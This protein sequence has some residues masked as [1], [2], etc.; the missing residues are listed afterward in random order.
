MRYSLSFRD[1]FNIA[2]IQRVICTPQARWIVIFLIVFF[3][4]SII[5]PAHAAILINKTKNVDDPALSDLPASQY[6]PFLSGTIGYT[7]GLEDALK[8]TFDAYHQ[9]AVKGNSQAQNGLSRLYAYG[10]GVPRNSA[11]SLYWARKAADQGNVQAAD[12]LGQYFVLGEGVPYNYAEGA[13]WFHKVLLNGHLGSGAYENALANLAIL[14]G[15]T[16]Y[17]PSNCDDAVSWNTLPSRQKAYAI[18]D[19]TLQRYDQGIGLSA[20]MTQEL[21]L[22]RASAEHELSNPETTFETMQPATVNGGFERAA[23]WYRHTA[24]VGDPAGMT[25]LGFQYLYGLG[26]PQNNTLAY[27]WLRKSVQWGDDAAAEVTLGNM[28]MQ[29]VGVRKNVKRAACWYRKAAAQHNSA[30]EYELAMLLYDGKDVHHDYRRGFTLLTQSAWQGDARALN[31]LSM[32]YAPGRYPISNTLWTYG[33]AYFGSQDASLVD[34]SV[35]DEDYYD[36]LIQNEH[37]LQQELTPLQQAQ[38]VRNVVMW[39]LHQW[40]VSDLPFSNLQ[41]LLP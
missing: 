22:L 14:S 33:L 19:Y 40:L 4:F 16:L 15:R 25:E 17:Y 5:I 34:Q 26:V 31:A 18:K 20:A 29:G 36:S 10:I 28:Y 12:A 39:A 2:R 41:P 1:R 30:G 13:C 6:V 27:R 37:Q 3:A 21:I 11:Q 9:A 38:A 32:P 8:Q 7:P 24:A 23:T 35:D